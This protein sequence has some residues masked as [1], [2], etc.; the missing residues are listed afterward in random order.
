MSGLPT[1]RYRYEGEGEFRALP[2]YQKLCDKEL[3]V[4]EIYSLGIIEERSQASHSHYFASLNEAYKNLPE[5]LAKNFRSVEHLRKWTLIRTG[6]YTSRSAIFPSP[7][8]AAEAA[9]WAGPMVD[10]F[11][12][13][14][15]EGNVVTIYRAKSQSVRAMGKQEFQQSKSDV[16]DY[17]AAMIHT[18]RKQLEENARKVA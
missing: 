13:T 9:T 18:S 5:E 7:R 15:V 8:E 16:L 2:H 4:G 1:L 3:V 6:Y 11:D 10:E 14:V 12:V 17:V